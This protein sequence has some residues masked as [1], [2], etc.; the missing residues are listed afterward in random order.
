MLSLS[1]HLG[2]A[3]AKPDG[4]EVAS[5]PWIP[6]ASDL[7]CWRTTKRFPSPRCAS[8][9]KIETTSERFRAFAFCFSGFYLLATGPGVWN[10]ANSVEL[11]IL[12][13]NQGS[14][15]RLADGCSIMTRPI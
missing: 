9:T 15:P 4:V 6:A 5:Q 1:G 13:T 8:A 2:V 10:S 14:G 11:L 3:S 7:R 12:V